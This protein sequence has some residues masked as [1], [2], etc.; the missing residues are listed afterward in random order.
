MENA[1]E[2]VFE[3]EK[4]NAAELLSFGKILDRRPDQLHG[5]NIATELARQLL[6]VRTRSGLTSP[7]CANAVQLAFEKH[8]EAHNIVLKARQMGL[9]T[10]AAARFFLRTITR[11]G[12]LTLRWRIRRNQPRRSSASFIASLI[13]CLKE[14]REGA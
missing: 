5:R 3:P 11:P 10:W 6:R 12:T 8:R 14:L 1:E 7:L 2:F 9:T 4:L 13:T